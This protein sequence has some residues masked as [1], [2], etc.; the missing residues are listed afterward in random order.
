M[1]LILLLM[2][3]SM[4][5]DEEN[6]HTPTRTHVMP[7]KSPPGVCGWDPPSI[8]LY[9]MSEERDFTAE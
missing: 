2:P 9:Y 3:I 4:G 8:R 7:L 6:S 1:A 5:K